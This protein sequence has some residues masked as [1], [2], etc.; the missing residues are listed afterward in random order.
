MLSGIG[1]QVSNNQDF[2]FTN[3]VV[4]DNVN[5]IVMPLGQARPGFNSNYRVYYQNLGTTI[6]N[7]AVSLTYDD[8]KLSH[9]ISNP[10]EDMSLYSHPGFDHGT[11]TYAQVTFQPHPQIVFQALQF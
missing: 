5:V 1:G 2:C 7:G 10:S 3:T 11:M 8:T 9:L 4:G 6:T